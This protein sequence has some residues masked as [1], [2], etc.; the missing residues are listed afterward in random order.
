M[1]NT[2]TP[3]GQM[4]AWDD[5]PRATRRV[6]LRI[7]THGRAPTKYGARVV[8]VGF[9]DGKLLVLAGYAHVAKGRSY[10]YVRAPEGMGTNPVVVPVDVP[11]DEEILRFAQELHREGQAVK[12]VIGPW[13]CYYYPAG[14]VTARIIPG[15][16]SYVDEHRAERAKFELGVGASWGVTLTWE[17]KATAPQWKR[18]EGNVVR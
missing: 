4:V 1:T 14:F 11:T 13:L 8:K 9:Q 2:D 16:D 17:G 12:G 6:Y 15:R 3:T 18:S 10:A 5:W 7:P